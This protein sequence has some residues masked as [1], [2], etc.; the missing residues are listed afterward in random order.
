MRTQSLLAENK[1]QEFHVVACLK[2]LSA[3]WG[4]ALTAS[5]ERLDERTED[6]GE[7]GGRG[8]P[9]AELDGFQD[10]P[11]WF[12]RKLLLLPSWSKLVFEGHTGDPKTHQH[13]STIR[14]S[15]RNNNQQTAEAAWAH[16]LKQTAGQSDTGV[17][18]WWEGGSQVRLMRL[19]TALLSA[20]QCLVRHLLPAESADLSSDPNVTSEKSQTVR[21]PTPSL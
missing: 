5:R 1:G 19:I 17:A 10:Q 7:G 13:T 6:G 16:S 15:Q 11:Q 14:L 21:K 3:E 2:L 4:G 12:S 18:R 9:G 20:S 8:A